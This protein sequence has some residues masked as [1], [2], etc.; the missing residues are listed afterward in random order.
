MLVDPSF[1][2]NIWKYQS[3][4]TIQ[5]FHQTTCYPLKRSYSSCGFREIGFIVM[6]NSSRALY[7]LRKKIDNVLQGI[8]I[9][10]FQWN[11]SSTCTAL[12]VIT[13]YVSQLYSPVVVVLVTDT[14]IFA[15]LDPNNNSHENKN[16]CKT[17]VRYRLNIGSIFSNLVNF[18]GHLTE[19]SFYCC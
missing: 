7:F 5:T 9:I 6:K 14:C 17:S 10:L 1:S 13:F 16:Q 15:N 12:L 11:W 4:A 18:N 2:E 3:I 19:P 8:S